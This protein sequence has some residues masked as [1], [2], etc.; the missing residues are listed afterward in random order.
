MGWKITDWELFEVP[1][2]VRNTNK[3]RA[4]LDY[5]QLPTYYNSNKLMQLLGSSRSGIAAF[6]LWVLLA[7]VWASQKREKRIGGVLWSWEDGRP[8][9]N[10]ELAKKLHLSKRLLDTL[11]PL[12]SNIEWLEQYPKSTEDLPWKSAGNPAGDIDS[13]YKIKKDKD[14][15]KD[16]V[17]VRPYVNIKQV[18]YDKLIE[19]FG[20]VRAEKMLDK[21]D[22]YKGA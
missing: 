2:D 3:F 21:L 4:G 9:S 17:S 8:A 11:C 10:S 12:L 7:E 6:G 20:K 14:Q 13:L 22:N 5:L 15:D 1:G 18:E 16:K 19:K